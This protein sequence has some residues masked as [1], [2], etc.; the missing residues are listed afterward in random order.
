[1]RTTIASLICL[2]V[3]FLTGCN[4]QS[5]EQDEQHRIKVNIL[6]IAEHFY[7]HT[8]TYMG[9]LEESHKVPLSMPAGGLITSV[10]CNV[11]NKVQAGQVLV[12]VDTT[13]A[14]QLYQSALATLYQAQDGYNRAQEVYQEGGITE[15]KMVEIRSQLTQAQAMANLAHKTLTDC[16]LRAPQA[17]TIG[18]CDVHVGQQIAP[19]ITIV[20][21]LDMNGLNVV[22]AVSEDEVNRIMVGD[23]GTIDV[24]AIGAKQLPIIV[25]EKTP[26][27]NPVARTYQ[28]KARCITPPAS[29][30]PNMIAR[31]QLQSQQVSGFLVP[32][33]AIGL[34]QNTPSLWVARD[35]T[36]VRQTVQIGEY[37]EDG[38][39]VT[40]GLN[41]GDQVIVS[42]IQKLWQ[43]AE[44]T[45]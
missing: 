32:R 3:F 10:K 42:G 8:H 25:V 33:A 34:Y 2:I 1:M 21:L 16:T 20:S 7:T 38:V 5:Q 37:I 43:G 35:S 44:I 4:L 36:A 28:V 40:E 9:E 19:G 30:L 24:A 22:F 41:E 26:T 15:Q 13:R 39:L 18:Q 11:G 6:T 27:A 31:V 45:Y 12:Q 29:L 14:G 23:S 17:G